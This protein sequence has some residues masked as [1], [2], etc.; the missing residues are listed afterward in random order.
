MRIR[1]AVAVAMVAAALAAAGGIA[2]ADQTVF[3]VNAPGITTLGGSK[4]T[5]EPAKYCVPWP[6]G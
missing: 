3:C 6:F 5:T 2:S 1:R 4:P